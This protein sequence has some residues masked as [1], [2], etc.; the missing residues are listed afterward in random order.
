MLG[1][2]NVLIYGVAAISGVAAMFR[3]Q[4]HSR[5]LFALTFCSSAACIYTALLYAGYIEASHFNLLGSEEDLKWAASHFW[6]AIMFI[7]FHVVTMKR[8]YG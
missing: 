8:A 3:I 6:K 7:G 4:P 5:L 2:L 1:I